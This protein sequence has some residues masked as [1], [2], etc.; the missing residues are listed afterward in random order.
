MMG[1]GWLQSMLEFLPSIVLC[2][3]FSLSCFRARASW[4]GRPW[5]QW[6]TLWV[7]GTQRLS[8]PRVPINFC[9]FLIRRSGS[10]LDPVI[11]LFWRGRWSTSLMSWLWSGLLGSWRPVIA[12]ASFMRFTFFLFWFLQ[13]KH[14]LERSF[15]DCQ[16]RAAHDGS[17]IGWCHG[18]S[19]SGKVNL[20][21]LRSRIGDRLARAKTIWVVS[22][23]P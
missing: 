23:I 18:N 4:S 13:K 2:T 7:L 19:S 22:V 21:I 14:V 12:S 9:D 11:P 8:W 6:L 10:V 3:V 1:S 20:N 15:K 5:M 16:F 17:G